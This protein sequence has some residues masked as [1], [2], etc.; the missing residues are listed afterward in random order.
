MDNPD[1]MTDAKDEYEKANRILVHATEIRAA[2]L[3]VQ[4][5]AAREYAAELSDQYEGQEMPDGRICEGVNIA[6]RALG[7]VVFVKHFNSGQSE[8]FI[9]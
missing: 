4:L 2:A 5:D 6:Y 7:H 8:D 9:P 3:Q 1:A